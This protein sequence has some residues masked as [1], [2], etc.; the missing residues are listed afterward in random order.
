MTR[1]TH[2]L[3]GR[4]SWLVTAMVSASML[5]AGVPPGRAHNNPG[6]KEVLLTTIEVAAAPLEE[7]AFAV[8]SEAFGLDLPKK[9]IE[10]IWRI[11][12]DEAG[13]ITFGVVQGDKRHAEGLGDGG[14][15]RILRGGGIRI[16]DVEGASAPFTLEVYANVI[17]R[18][19]PA[20][21]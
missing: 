19:K 12:G 15:S 1:V 9:T 6:F 11:R 5:A 3:F 17:D 8:H 16:V 13:A 7:G 18:P 4:R 21:S 20:D 14:N 2:V 10:L